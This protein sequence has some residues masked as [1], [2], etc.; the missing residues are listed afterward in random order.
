MDPNFVKNIRTGAAVPSAREDLL[1]SYVDQV[2]AL[3]EQVEELQQ[4]KDYVNTTEFQGL[5]AHEK[6]LA[7]VA[8]IHSQQEQKL[9]QMTEEAQRLVKVYNEI[10]L[11]L[12][13]QCMEWGEELARR[14]S[15]Q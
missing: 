11:Q 7:T 12:S 13:A 10:M 15:V 5:E 9:E 3:G 8:N 6:R 1:V 4:L 2:K 14:E